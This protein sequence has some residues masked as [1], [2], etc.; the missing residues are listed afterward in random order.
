MIISLIIIFLPLQAAFQYK[1]PTNQ[2]TGTAEDPYKV[3]KTETA[4]KIDAVL[5]DSAWENALLLELKY[6]V[7]PGENVPP[8]VQTE[9]L[10]TYDRENLY[11]AFRSYDPDPSAI[12]AHLR[13]RDTLGGDDWI[14]LIFDTFN[15]NR[16]SFDFIVTAMGVQFDEI[17]SQSG[18]DPGWDT[19]WDCASRITEWGYAVEIAI[20][21]SSLRFQRK[22]GPQIWGF[23]AVR[24]Y[25]REHAYHIGLFPRDRSNNCY[26][27]QALKIQGFEGASPGSN[28]EINPTII[29]VRTDERPE[30][31][32]GS[33]EKRDQEAEA[34]LTARWGMTPNLTLN[35]TANPDFSQVEA[36]A[37][38]LD[39]NQPFALFYP[40][41]RPF[42][43]E[44]ADF[45]SALESIIYTRTVRDPAWG[46]K[47]TGK[48]GAHTIGAYVLR[49]EV[50][51]LIFPG[52]QN[53]SSASL[54]TANTSSVFRYKRDFGSRYTAGILATDREGKGYFNRILG[55]DLD[56]RLTPTNQIQL[57]ILGSSTRYPV[58]VADSYNQPAG[59]FN[60]RLIS[61]EYDHYTRTWGWW[62]DYEDVGP[63]FRADLG[64]FPRVGY[65]NAE[66]GLLYSWN[67]QPG[68]WWSAFKLGGEFN[69]FED[70]SGALLNRTASLWF[71]YTGTMQS[72]LYL[73][74]WISREAYNKI[75]FKKAYFLIE[76]GFWPASSIQIYLSAIF[77]EEI[78]YANT[79]P[80]QRIRL[81]PY[82]SYNLG[83]HLRFSLNH[84]YER[85]MV[86]N[87]H[88]YTANIS[89]SMVVYQFNVRTFLR[90]IF[91]YVNY[92]YNPSNYT[93]DIEPKNERFFTQ[94]LFSYK[95][96]ARTVLFLGY[97]D[98]YFG[99]QDFRLTQADRTFFLKI[100]YAWVF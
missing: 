30:F 31:P 58:E 59:T 47:L 72:S 60:D 83:K 74:G 52:S 56:F 88:L 34:G 97:S 17:E 45:F 5:A 48:E 43:T 78:D 84:T 92:D 62:A 8:P 69:Y 20:P 94:L 68:S 23:D 100:G 91:Q 82:L 25:P 77:G 71:S 2:G 15:D 33:L 63:E 98:N 1:I 53:S 37:M 65:R 21:F 57:L 90:A 7:R 55:L 9:V 11:A 35:L 36:D 89:Q 50:T 41:R 13:D 79:R 93:F 16:R 19:I 40:E 44:G 54:N 24:R 73:R 46:I 28:I 64:Y 96:N 26:L 39:I 76:G 3:P 95:I 29:G 61:F 22:D 42:F 81:N 87:A 67:A 10:L 85:M 75:K 99:G 38:Q 14:A 66:G 80:G 27:C 86:Q 70:R 12:R 32:S 6:E 18:E 51:N 49:D 4:V